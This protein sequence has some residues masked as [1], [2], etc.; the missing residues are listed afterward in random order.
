M[1]VAA[2]FD[3]KVF[4]DPHRLDLRRSPNPHLAFGHGA[5]ICMGNMLA[6]GVVG[7]AVTSLVRR[8]PDLQ[9]VEDSFEPRLDLFAM[10]G[11]KSLKVRKS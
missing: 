11:M 4:A 8:F 3:P 2:N 1:L 5:H 6:R 9:M 7:H 10:Q